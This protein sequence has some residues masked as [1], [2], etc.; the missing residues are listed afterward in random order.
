M[1][2]I[3]HKAQLVDKRVAPALLITAGVGLLWSHAWILS[4]IILSAGAI[5]EKNPLKQSKKKLA[6]TRRW[7]RI[8]YGSLLAAAILFWLMPNLWTLP[9]LVVLLPFLLMISNAFW[10]PIESVAHDFRY[11][12]KAQKKLCEIN[13]ITIGITGSFGKTSVKNIIQHVLSAMESSYATPKSI[14]TVM[15]VVRVINQELLPSHK[16]FVVEM[17]TDR[18][19]G[20]L[21]KLCELIKPQYGILTAIGGAHLENYK[22]LDQLAAEK[23][24]LLKASGKT[25]INSAQVAQKYIKEYAADNADVFY[26]DTISDIEIKSDGLH[27]NFDGHKIFAPV[28]ST[29]Q[30]Y[31]IALSFM[32][33]RKIGM[34]AS[35]II[36]AL[37]TLPQTSHRSEVLRR[38][39]ITII[40]DGYNS[41]LDGFLSALNTTKILANESGGRTIIITPGIVEL[42]AKHAEYHKIIGQR[43]SALMDVVIAVAFDRIKDFTN[44]ISPEKLVT[45]MTKRDADN[46]LAK[47]AQPGDVI[48][49]E[50]D[51]P[52]FFE[53]KIRI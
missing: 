29:V 6:R 21:G 3:F 48:L 28:Y 42:G 47:N 30:A 27:F 26:S 32:M 9:M 20:S 46:W 37:R 8:F 2:F 52:D 25:I 22:S 50:N 19:N 41:N 17:G 24:K 38:G 13:P 16:Y 5:I 4:C 14:N 43:A 1:K 7:Q 11:I 53:E 40:D 10:K 35:N 49:Y 23:A 18:P 34:P 44:E 12:R 39:D 51:L 31:N 15:G 33:L 36:L 45:V